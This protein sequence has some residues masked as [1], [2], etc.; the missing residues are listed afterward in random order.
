M[1][2]EKFYR[3]WAG[4][5]KTSWMVPAD[6]LD[7]LKGRNSHF[8]STCFYTPEQVETFK[9]TKTV[10]GITDVK[11]NQLWFDFDSHTDLNKPKEDAIELVDRIT[12]YFHSDSIEIYYSGFKGFHVLVKLDREITPYQVKK[13]V[14]KFGDNLETLD[15]QV[16][17][18]NR[19]LRAENTQHEKTGLFKIPLTQTELA[20]FSIDKI[21]ELAKTQRELP[22]YTK[23]KTVLPA[24]LEFL[25]PEVK[26]KIAA[27]IDLTDPLRIKEIDFTQR[28][29]GF[30]DY[31]WALCMGRFEIGQRNHSLMVIASTCRALKYGR[32]HTEAI[33]RAADKMHCDITND[34]AVDD[35]ALESEVLDVVFGDSW[36]G[37]Q[38]SVDNDL[39]LRKYCDKYGF[40]TEKDNTESPVMGL[41][42]V[43]ETFRD[44]VKNIDKN[45]IKTG[46][47]KLDEALPITIGMN[48]GLVGSAASGKTSIALEI[49][50]NTSMSGVVS[51]IASL[52]MHRNRLFEKVLYKVSK[53]VYGKTLNKAELYKKFH[54]NEDGLLVNE[55]KRQFGNVY[56]YDRSSPRVSDL[57]N[58]I[59]TVEASTGQKVKL[60]MVDYFERI[61]SD[62]ADATA[63]SLKVANELQDLLNDLNLAIITLV[64]PNKFSLAG[65]PDSPILSYTSIKGS[66]FLYQSFRAIVSIWRPF[67][68]PMTKEL[69]NF[70]EM[71]ILKNDLGEQ[72]HFKFHWEGKTGKISDMT[73]EHE[74]Q[75]EDALA[76]KRAILAPDND[77]DNN[78]NNNGPYGTFRRTPY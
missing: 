7:G 69:D 14:T 37:G 8:V 63:S 48:L 62:V 72:D 17:D 34:S 42:E 27:P 53:D 61:G 30:K 71:A 13:I 32:E 28:P 55:V 3:V 20:I 60:L 15:M 23:L 54:D 45:T 5:T 78:R 40:A 58:F 35:Y 11:T 19:I 52:D 65:G 47:K 70:L 22:S 18:A 33:C 76:E 59:L 26:L 73:S 75:Y 68:T 6:K 39:A 66:S 31:K 51:V 74:Q 44:F 2:T 50:K 38:Y 10:K 49:L 36:N 12:E 77:D 43:N 4:K 41:H 57:R 21:K 64:Q 25:E 16:Y 46:I 29:T 24:E 1:S 9:K 67:F 56:F